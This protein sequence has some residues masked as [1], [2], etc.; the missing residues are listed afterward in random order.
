MNKKQIVIV[1]IVFSIAMIVSIIWWIA[2]PSWVD[3]Y[4][5][6][7]PQEEKQLA[8]E[9]LSNVG[10]DYKYDEGTKKILIESGNVGRARKLLAENGVPKKTGIGLEIFAN[11]DYGLSEFVQ[12]INYQRGMEE[13]LARTI[14]AMNGIK[15]ARVHLTIKKP[16][17]FDEKRQEPKASVILTLKEGIAVDKYQIRGV[18]EMVASALPGLQA[19]AVIVLSEKGR[20]ISDSEATGASEEDQNGIELKYTKIVSDLLKGY[21]GDD[22]YNVSVNV[23]IDRRKKTTI[24]ENYFPDLKTGKG[25]ITRSKQSDKKD[26]LNNQQNSTSQTAKEEEFIYSKERSEISYPSGEISRVSIGIIVKKLLSAEEQGLLK[27]LVTKSIGLEMVRGDTISLIIT[28]DSNSNTSK[29]YKDNALAQSVNGIEEPDVSQGAI[30]NI[31]I[32]HYPIVLGMLFVLFLSS[33]VLLIKVLGSSATK[34]NN[35]SSHEREKL[36]FELKEWMK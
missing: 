20:V 26:D 33:L 30:K 12:N 35:I 11:S 31:F 10:I 22:N 24:E 4:P 2:S 27:D 6:E 14:R 29:D 7:M 34:V 15:D 8:V 16:S 28:K 36:I 1:G 5:T 13:E 21:L 19:D 3:L 18:Q 25:F 23:V 32:K 9:V 17:L